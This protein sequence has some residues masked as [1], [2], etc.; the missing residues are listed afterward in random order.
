MFKVEAFVED[1]YLAHVLRALAQAKAHDVKPYPVANTVITPNGIKAQARGGIGQQVLARLRTKTPTA[2]DIKKA[3]SEAGYS[4]GSY[5]NAA[6]Q[7]V[8]EKLL[9]RKSRGHY[10]V[11]K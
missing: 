1:K 5:N 4:T 11:V 10:G 9:K 6:T 7:M 3:L 2:D 8:K